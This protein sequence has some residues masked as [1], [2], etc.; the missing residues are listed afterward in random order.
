M[1]SHLEQLR[2]SLP[3]AWLGEAG[4]VA[5][6]A[7]GNLAAS[8]VDSPILAWADGARTPDDSL[9]SA[10]RW[11]GL[12]QLLLK[13][14]GEPRV[15]FDARIG[16]PPK[17]A[18]KELKRRARTCWPADS[19]STPRP[20]STC[21]TPCVRCRRAAMPT[22]NGRCWSPQFRVL[23]LAAAELEVVFSER[24]VADYPRFAAA[25]RDALGHV[26][27]TDRH[28]RWRSTPQLRHVLVDEFQDTSEAQVRLLEALTAGW[29]RGDGRTLFLVGDPMQSI[30]RFRNAEVG[31]FLDIRAGGVRGVE[32]EPLTLAGE[33][34]LER[35]VVEWV[36]ECF[37]QVLPAEDHLLHGAVRYTPSVPRTDAS[38]EGGVRVHALLRRSRLYEAQQVAAI[39]EARLA[40]CSSARI[41]IL[42]QGRSHLLDVVAELARR[43]I[44]FRA[45]DIDPLGER[46]VVLDLLALTRALA[47]PADRP[48]WLAL[49]RAPWCGLTL[50]ALHTL[51]AD[52]REATVM[53][54]LRDPA[55][56][57]RLDEDSRERLERAWSILGPRRGELRSFGLRDTVER[58]GTRSA[59]RPRSSSE[60]E[61]DEAEAYLDTLA[62]L[63]SRQAG[64]VDLERLSRALET[65]YAPSR[66]RADVR[67]ELLTVHKAKGLQYDTVIV[68]GLERLPG[69]D[70]K[71][72]LHWLK[73]PAAGHDELVVAP[74][75][76]AGRARMRST[77]GSRR[78]SDEKLCTSADACCTWQRRVPSAG[79]TCSAARGC[80]RSEEPPSVARPRAIRRSACCG[81]GRCDVRGAAGGARRVRGRGRGA[82]DRFPPLR[83]LPS[84]WRAGELP[85]GPHHR[86]AGRG[87]RG[88]R[89]A[90]EFDWASETAR[91][92]GT[93]VHRE[94]QRMTR[95][96]ACHGPWR[97]ARRR[98][99]YAELAEPGVRGDCVRRRWNASPAR[100]SD[101][102]H[103]RGR[104]L[105]DAG[106]RES[107]SELALTGR[108]GAE[109]VRVVIDRMFVDAAGVR[110]IVDYKTSRHEGAGLEEFL[111]REQE[112]YRPQLE[113]YAALMRKLGPQPVRL[114]LYFPLMAHGA[115]GSLRRT[116]SVPLRLSSRRPSA[117]AGP[118]GP[119]RRH[120]R[121]R[122]CRAARPGL[123]AGSCDPPPAS[124]R[125]SKANGPTCP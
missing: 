15:A 43:G 20:P 2:R 48:A 1:R 27:C 8:G 91:H 17:E 19:A 96:G 51:V 110:W 50:G 115:S 80:W 10:P 62:D 79:C 22:R 40:E 123:R 66:E 34:P 89:L 52:D 60:R 12:A 76:R 13:A 38:A 33:F 87:P 59:G 26:G 56:L 7:A 124:S 54:M 21:C 94:L 47:H 103:D 88:G 44:A 3:E 101:A 99:W 64:P 97:P 113:R 31:L 63:E 112:R 55:R 30:Y 28:S 107:A 45:I 6:I 100:S 85:P 104:W 46:P 106:H 109:V 111:D 121:R 39:T 35:A 49:L 4:E 57:A 86:V 53:E 119:G 65:L 14:D 32:L 83:R 108:L 82:G 29:Q 81:H 75:S 84:E 69:R 41:G 114:G 118:A 116:Q 36:N 25:A 58:H 93:V 5:A 16:F 23:R 11:Q 117:S 42:V 24:R 77:P 18:G 74:L 67:V 71:R 102:A 37:A 90:V 72:L 73:L 92:V 120:R 68:P 61:L 9:D 95:D 78:S 70:S 122:R 105:L 125:P 98:R